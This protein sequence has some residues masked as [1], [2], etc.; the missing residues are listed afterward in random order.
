[1]PAP[2]DPR[3]CGHCAGSVA[4]RPMAMNGTMMLIRKV[5]RVSSDQASIQEKLPELRRRS[6]ALLAAL[7][8]IHECED[9]HRFVFRNRPLASAE[10]FN[11]L[12]EHWQVVHMNQLRIT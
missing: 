4:G 11:D 6:P 12:V 7:R 9:F 8:G 2:C 3:Y 5:I 10:E 1:M